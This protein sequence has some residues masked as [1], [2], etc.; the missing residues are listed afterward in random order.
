[1]KLTHEQIEEIR[2]RA[3][4]FPNNAVE[5]R[6]MR[7]DLHDVIS[8]VSELEAQN[9]RMREVL[10]HID[11]VSDDFY[12]IKP[13]NG[14]LTFVLKEE[15]ENYRDTI[16]EIAIVPAEALKELSEDA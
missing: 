9:K 1:M 7:H 11:E 6:L 13:V 15:L 4:Y 14:T 12:D 16:Q 2:K 3:Q 5:L 10:E 8:H